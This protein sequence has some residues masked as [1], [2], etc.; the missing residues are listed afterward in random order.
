MA[1]PLQLEGCTMYSFLV[2]AG[3]DALTRLCTSQLDPVTRPSGFVYRPVLPMA[4]IVCADVAKSWSLTPPDSQKGWMR[5]RDFGVWIPLAAGKERS[6]GRFDVDRLAW[7][8]PYVFVDNVAAMVTGREVYGFFKQTATLAMPAAPTGGGAFSADALVIRTFSPSSTA[9]IARLLDVTS[10]VGA[11]A[12]G[13]EF[14]GLGHA[15]EAVLGEVKRAFFDPH[16]HLPLPTWALLETLLKDAIEG[17]VPMVFLKQLRDVTE[18]HKAC[19]QAVIEAPA[20]L[21]RWRGGGF[22]HPHD[23]AIL[24]CDSHPIASDLGL[25]GPSVRAEVG[26]WTRIDFTMQAGRE[27]A[28]TI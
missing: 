13:D 21:G 2:G 22:T 23:V 26:F 11:A 19:Y 4:A 27:V 18:P 5:E 28:R 6:D 17:L 20:K 15:A 24:P 10:P 16:E 1:G 3:H 8:L 12:P 7:Y 14:G 25:A 9:E